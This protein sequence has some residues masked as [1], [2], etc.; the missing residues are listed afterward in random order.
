MTCMDSRTALSTSDLSG[1][2]R[3]PGWACNS[4][5][6]AVHQ[7]SEG[8]ECEQAKNARSSAALSLW[9]AAHRGNGHWRAQHR[10]W[11]LHYTFLRSQRFKNVRWKARRKARAR[12]CRQSAVPSRTSTAAGSAAQVATS[13]RPGAFEAEHG[14]ATKLRA[15]YGTWRVRAIRAKQ[16]RAAVRVATGQLQARQ[17]VSTHELARNRS[18]WAVSSYA[19]VGHAADHVFCGCSTC[20]K[21]GHRWAARTCE[22][23]LWSGCWQARS[24]VFSYGTLTQY[25]AT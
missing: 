16:R 4:R 18:A 1:A 11:S 22:Q 25:Y 2:I 12:C 7:E 9:H 21:G 17:A 10:R 19:S 8:L 13:A 5:T 14:A 15:K 3:G 20:G 23:Q 24:E 6:N